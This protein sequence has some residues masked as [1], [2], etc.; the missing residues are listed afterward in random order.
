MISAAE[1]MKVIEGLQDDGLCHTSISVDGTW[2]RRGF[3]SLNGAVAAISMGTGKV[4]DVASMSRHCQ[5]C[6]N[7]NALENSISIDKFI[8][9]K[10]EHDCS[11]THIGSVEKHGVVYSGY[12][13]DGDSKGYEKVKNV[14]PGV[15]VSKYECV[16][17]VQKRVGNRLRKLKKNVKGLKGLTDGIIDKL[18]NYYGITIR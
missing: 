1:D 4:L 6:V 12:L 18:Q 7:I 14:Y 2:Q 11:I 5:G 8:E 10:A 3:S 16:G 9:L 15:L 13:G 17:H